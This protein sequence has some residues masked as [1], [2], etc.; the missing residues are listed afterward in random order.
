MGHVLKLHYD[1]NKEGK[2]NVLSTSKVQLPNNLNY[3]K[4]VEGIIDKREDKDY[5]F[6]QAGSIRCFVPPATVRI[7]NLNKGD[8]VGGLIVYGF[9]KKKDSWNWICV[10]IKNKK[11]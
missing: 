5:A 11:I 10:N 6:L 7:N 1:I 9:D 2:I 8:K 3:A 4:H